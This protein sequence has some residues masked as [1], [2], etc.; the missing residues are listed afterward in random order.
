MEDTKS[1]FE[2]AGLATAA[3]TEPLRM[4]EEGGACLLRSSKGEKTPS[5]VSARSQEDMCIFHEDL[6]TLIDQK[7]LCH[8]QKKGYIPMDE[9]D[10]I[11]F[12][13]KTVAP[14]FRKDKYNA[15]AYCFEDISFNLTPNRS[16]IFLDL[17][18]SILPDFDDGN[19]D[20]DKGIS[21]KVSAICQALDKQCK[22]G[23]D[24]VYRKEFSHVDMAGPILLGTLTKRAVTDMMTLVGVN[25]DSV[26][27]YV[28]HVYDM[29][30][31]D[32]V[33]VS[34]NKTD[35]DQ[36]NP[37]EKHL[38]SP[39][40]CACCVF[41]TQTRGFVD[42]T[43]EVMY[44]EKQD[45]GKGTN[46][47]EATTFLGVLRSP[48]HERSDRLHQEVDFFSSVINVHDTSR[49]YMADESPFRQCSIIMDT[50]TEKWVVVPTEESSRPPVKNKTHHPSSASA[51]AC[52]GKT[53]D[54]FWMKK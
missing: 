1:I 51:S 34:G 46:I 53:L 49:C 20:T 32:T 13:M 54:L 37:G 18:Y 9:G 25:R 40:L 5:C 41:A 43:E 42:C 7:A 36:Y 21:L 50:V 26:L 24:C 33:C 47:L 3:L 35:V 23:N 48:A 12:D 16:H 10:E 19:N 17:L 2:K 6:L 38:K 22:R 31:E 29:L 15:A 44:L 39:D 8:M 28:N 4:I 14:W 11:E 27:A 52:K 30:L 45:K